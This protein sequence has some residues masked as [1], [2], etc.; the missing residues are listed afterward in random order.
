MN[1]FDRLLKD[2]HSEAHAFA[3]KECCAEFDDEVASLFESHGV[4][5]RCGHETNTKDDRVQC[6][7]PSVDVCVDCDGGTYCAG[8]LVNVTGPEEGTRETVC[9][10][11]GADRDARTKAFEEREKK[12]AKE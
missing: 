5:L 1:L 2:I 11:C 4:M 12:R 3:K 8:H 10:G 9:V 6:P 7:L